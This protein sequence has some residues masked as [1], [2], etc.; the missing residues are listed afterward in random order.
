MAETSNSHEWARVLLMIRLMRATLSAVIL[1]ASLWVPA[2]ASNSASAS[3]RNSRSVVDSGGLRKISGN[4]RSDAS[5]GAMSA[6]SGG[7]ASFANR[8]GFMGIAYQPARITDLSASSTCGDTSVLL[9][10]TAPGNDGD[11]NTTAGAYVLKYSSVASESPS[12]SDAK[13][14][15]ATS[16]ALPPAPAIRSTSHALTVSGLIAGVPYYFAIKAAERDG[17]RSV[18]GAGTNLIGAGNER[19][20]QAPYGIGLSTAANSVTVSWLPV[21]RYDDRVA[22]ANPNAPTATELT[23]YHVYRATTP[24]HASWVELPTALSTAT[25]T[26]TDVGYGTT[27][28]YAVRSETFLSCLATT[29]LSARSLIRSA[30]TFDA[31]SVAPDD[32]SYFQIPKAL[33][34]PLVGTP[35]D[36]ASA[37]AIVTSSSADKLEGRVFK[38]LEF[39]AYRGGLTLDT[40]FTLG[41]MGRIYAHYGSSLTVTISGSGSPTNSSIYWWNG[42]KYLQLYGKS[43]ALTQNMFLETKYF[44]KYQLRTVERVTSFAFN[45]AGLSN[46]F[47]TPNG[48]GKN[49]AVVFT[50]DNPHDT[51]ISGRILD[52]RGRVVANH[53]VSGPAPNSLQWDGTAGGRGVPAGMYIYQL[54]GEGHSFTGTLV[55]LK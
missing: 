19:L 51:V 7:S 16:V 14:D 42:E 29:A 50:F 9:K 41:G 3:F 30:D 11:E 15:A 6:P 49:D 32:Q 13:F 4:F 26:V 47:V 34:A 2:R 52:L 27:Y 5:V 12:I 36:P 44:G 40:D 8:D 43:N 31:Y 38:A 33:V 53:L 37:Y 17:V 48:D 46:R 35:G 23:G 10:W 21:V 39:M 1:S 54:D 22:F 24:I 18:L 28:Y 55:V 25:L 45:V 20:A